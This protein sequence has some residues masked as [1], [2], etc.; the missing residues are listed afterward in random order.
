MWAKVLAGT[1]LGATM[2]LLAS[3]SSGSSGGSNAG[4]GGAPYQVGFST[5]LSAAY[6]ALGTGQR[7]GFMAYINYVNSK[8]GVHGRKITVSIADDGADVT[9]G[10]A[11][12]TQ[13]ITQNNA[14]VTAGTLLSNV[15]G[16]DA[17]IATARKVPIICSALPDDILFPVHPYIYSARI[18]QSWE[19]APEIAFASK[20][21]NTPSP[22]VAI[23]GYGSAATLVLEK[24]LSTVATAKGLTVT[25]S[26]DVPFGSTD[27]S[28]QAAKVIASKPDVIVGALPDALSIPFMRTLKSGG[29]NVP[30]ITYDGA[31]L[32]GSLLALKDPNLYM[33]STMTLDGAGSSPGLGTY[34]DALK[35]ANVDPTQPFVN[36]GY[37][38]AIQVVEGLKACAADC[39]GDK[40]KAALDTLKVDTG[41]VTS[42]PITFTP[43]DH[44]ALKNASFYHWD[45]TQNAVVEA[46]SGIAGGATA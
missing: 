4:G 9:R 39:T 40:M 1:A 34:R 25:T 46:A 38:Q 6:S 36:V 32:K 37:V 43:D 16:A 22:K 8:G 12:E 13:F 10:T 24:N 11:N 33:L 21:A 20:V 23:I 27:L 30:F 31:T 44:Q 42:G 45:S 17:P 26:Q 35:A 29:L 19:A 3:C 41:G 28:A 5:D 7:D 14:I 2:V 18:S 15:C